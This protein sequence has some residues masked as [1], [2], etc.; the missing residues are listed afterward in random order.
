MP[1]SDVIS[2]SPFLSEH[3]TSLAVK[4]NKYA[5]RRIIMMEIGNHYDRFLSKWIV[6]ND[7]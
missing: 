5:G 2:I 6:D 3:Q 4:N 1:M 7:G